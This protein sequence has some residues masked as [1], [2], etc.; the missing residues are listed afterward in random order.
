[1]K[2]TSLKSFTIPEHLGTIYLFLQKDSHT[3]YLEQE[4][5]SIKV[6]L[7]IKNKQLHQQE[8][9]LMEVDKL[10]R[11]EADEND[12]RASRQTLLLTEHKHVNHSTV[13]F[14]QKEKNVKLDE[15]LKKVQQENEDLKARM[16]RHA[17]L[18]R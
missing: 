13:V 11:P 2:C 15:S 5:E 4:L 9:Q 18:S 17:A 16:D 8:K 1:M 3:L 7:D 12:S 14:F 6:V 10:V